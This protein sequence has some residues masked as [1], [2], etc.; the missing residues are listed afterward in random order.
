[1]QR[2]WAEFW[3]DVFLRRLP[4]LAPDLDRRREERAEWLWETLDLQPGARV[5]DLGCGNGMVGVS[6]ARRGA[7]V[8]GVDRIGSLLA[9]AREQAGELPVTFQ[10]ND[11]RA[12]CFAQGSFDAVMLLDVVGLMGRADDESLVRRS[13][14][15]LKPGGRMM[16]DCPHPPEALSGTSAWDLPEGRVTLASTYDAA[17]RLLHLEPTFHAADGTTL[18]LYDPYDLLKPDHTGV[19]RYVYPEAE[20]RAMLEEAGFAV[21][22][23]PHPSSEGHFVLLGRV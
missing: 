6:L 9:H 1:M 10:C 13:A 2:T 20:L 21:R 12:V 11:L 16:V 3:G 19:L 23:L 8:T 15:W 17:T 7:Q 4:E 14:G 18:E 5:L 22:Q